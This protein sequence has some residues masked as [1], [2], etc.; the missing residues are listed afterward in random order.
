MIKERYVD[1]PKFSDVWNNPERIFNQDKTALEFG[2][3]H[4]SV[5][6]P[7]YNKGGSLRDH[8][9]SASIT[10]P[11]Q[12]SVTGPGQASV[13]LMGPSW[14]SSTTAPPP[15]LLQLALRSPVQTVP[16]VP[17]ITPLILPLFSGLNP[18]SYG[19]SPAEAETNTT[20]ISGNLKPFLRDL[21][22]TLKV[23]IL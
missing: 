23:V 12:A 21:T 5:L 17:V 15:V 19:A 22:L 2:S 9:T 10:T 13:S 7:L 18:P 20:P 6:G 11:R 4:Q 3:K 8:V 14:A 1:S 16:P